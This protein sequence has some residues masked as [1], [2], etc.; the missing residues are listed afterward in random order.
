[1]DWVL[2]SRLVFGALDIETCADCQS[3]TDVITSAAILLTEKEVGMDRP[4]TTNAQTEG[5]KKWLSL[6]SLALGAVLMVIIGLLVWL[7][8]KRNAIVVEPFGVPEQYGKDGYSNEVI[9]KKLIEAVR[10]AEGSVKIRRQKGNEVLVLSTEKDILTDFEVPATKLSVRTA[11]SAVRKLLGVE[12]RQL[13]GDIVFTAHCNDGNGPALPVQTPV[14]ITIRLSPDTGNAPPNTVCVNNGKSEE[15][16]IAPA[17]E[18]ILERLNPLVFAAYLGLTKHEYARS[19]EL[20]DKLINETNQ[21]DHDSLSNCY[22]LRGVI[23]FNAQKA[24]DLA[25]SD[26]REDIN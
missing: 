24:D 4:S 14:E 16:M 22:N 7:D 1:M 8:V 26:F 17:S 10:Q 3:N 25:I 18:A 19:I 11:I 6:V 9:T 13:S 15:A 12:Q 20:T 2:L 23:Y 5:T 21:N